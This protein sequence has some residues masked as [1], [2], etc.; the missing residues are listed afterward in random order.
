MN[1]NEKCELLHA[2]GGNFVE[3]AAE[4]NM[5]EDQLVEEEIKS[6]QRVLTAFTYYEEYS[7][8]WLQKMERDFCSLSPKHKV[9][10]NV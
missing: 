5:N 1:I 7:S 2:Q 10:I 6:F 3:H 9:D 4:E 8:R